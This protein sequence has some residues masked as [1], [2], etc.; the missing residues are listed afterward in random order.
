MFGSC[1]RVVDE[2]PF[3]LTTFAAASAGGAAGK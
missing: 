3:A 2:N 1:L